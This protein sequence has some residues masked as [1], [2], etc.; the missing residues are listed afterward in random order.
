MR[1]HIRDPK[2]GLYY[3]AW[4]YSKKAPWADPKTGLSP[5]F[6]GRAIGW[7]AVAIVD[8]L[9][10]IPQD[11]ANRQEFIDT[12]RDLLIALARYQDEKSGLWYQVVDKGNRKE[13]WTEASCSALIVYALSKAVRMGYLGSEYKKHADK[14]CRGIIET[15]EITADGSLRIP[16]ICEGTCLGDY[17]FYINRKRE[18]NDLHGVGAFV[19]MCTEHAKLR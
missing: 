12:V 8:M 5:E 15:T 7:F 18:V 3:H 16:N 10:Y 6:W 13:N 9:D 11:Y 14:G 19:L 2:T 17:D 4:D 1:L